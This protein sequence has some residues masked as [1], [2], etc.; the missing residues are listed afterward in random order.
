M[1]N[2]AKRRPM[3]V[4]QSIHW[5]PL[6]DSHYIVASLQV[7]DGG[8][9]QIF[10]E[11][12]VLARLQFVV[13]GAHG[14]R[15]AGL[16][17]GHVFECSVTGIE[18][19]V[20]DQLAEKGGGTSGDHGVLTEDADLAASIGKALRSLTG[21]NQ[22]QLLGWYR[23][24]A[25]VDA[26]PS[27]TDATLHASY[28]AEP[29]QTLL[30][31][32]AG[33][34]SGAGGAF[35]LRDG[36]NS[37]WFY[38]PFYELATEAPAPNHPTVTYVSWPQYMTADEVT[39]VHIEPTPAPPPSPSPLP[40]AVLDDRVQPPSLGD[41]GWVNVDQDVE[42]GDETIQFRPPRD[43]EL[44]RAPTIE[45][46]GTEATLST[47]I[48]PATRPGQSGRRGGGDAKSAKSRFFARL[49][50]R[51]VQSTTAVDGVET[52]TG[53][54]RTRRV[55]DDDDTSASD[56]S[57]RFIELARSE[58]FFVATRFDA[59]GESGAADALWV[60]NE[61][62]SGLLLTVVTSG[63][64]VVDA[65]LH[66]NL[67][68]DDA[69]LLRVPFP[70]H[71][72]PESK[73]IYVRETCVEGLRERC[74]RLRATNA[75]VR[76]WKVAPSLSFLTPGEWQSPALLNL[77]ATQAVAIVT[78]LNRSRVAELPEAVRDQFRLTRDR[79]DIQ[80]QA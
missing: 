51:E 68:T 10:V 15:V 52:R 3:P 29:W 35:F 77:D 75:L 80:R 55:S 16:L 44:S 17:L 76:D 69:G 18:Y 28:F 66:Y 48:P 72:D 8:R 20:I 53:S 39:P 24:A 40:Q 26:K 46:A 54:P 47:P 5:K 60:L 74:R 6:R 34:H 70:E 4:D 58:G 63:P 50:D 49:G 43:I 64:E 2:R 79:G 59:A 61:P 7:A 19:M 13:R 25:G 33:T 56:D 36:K 67:Q 41:D 42:V 37:R 38:A 11:Q 12:H 73:T 57:A 78:D 71:R 45:P 62:Y 14:H 21:R 30:V 65:S 22:P 27:P 1:S 23:V 32:A 31:L 9:R